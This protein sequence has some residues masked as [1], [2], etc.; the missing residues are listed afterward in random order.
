LETAPR[1][2]DPITRAGLR[3]SDLLLWS[4]NA[5]RKL[6]PTFA[7]VPATSKRLCLPAAARSGW[8]LSRAA[9]AVLR[10]GACRGAARFGERQLQSCEGTELRIA[11][12]ING[13][14]GETSPMPPSNPSVSPSIGPAG[15]QDEWSHGKSRHKAN[16]VAE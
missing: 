9:R 5:F 11:I 6:P 16:K 3:S 10:A 1:P 13:P 2:L 15:A 8:F 7:P 12:G 4:Q 14:D